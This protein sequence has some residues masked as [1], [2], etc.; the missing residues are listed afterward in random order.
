MPPTLPFA[1]PQ[2]F[3]PSDIPAFTKAVAHT[4]FDGLKAM[5]ERIYNPITAILS[6]FLRFEQSESGQENWSRDG[7]P[8]PV[9]TYPVCKL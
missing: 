2:I 6:P 4:V 1:P 3:R 7:I 5:P 8:R 9:Y